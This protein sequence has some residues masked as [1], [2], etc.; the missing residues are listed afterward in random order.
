M[1]DNL[2]GRIESIEHNAKKREIELRVV[3]ALKYLS[4][5]IILRKKYMDQNGNDK[6]QFGYQ[7]LFGYSIPTQIS[8]DRG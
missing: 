4:Q 8:S 2:G 3:F 7:T 5:Y 1:K 6:Y